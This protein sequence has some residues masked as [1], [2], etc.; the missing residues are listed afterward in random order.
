MTNNGVGTIAN[1]RK[2]FHSTHELITT[3]YHEAGHAV[4][5]LLKCMKIEEVS[6]FENKKTKRIEG[7]TYYKSPTPE[8]RKTR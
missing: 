2:K 7:F 3:S 1:V 4:Y 5:G 6:V 8:A